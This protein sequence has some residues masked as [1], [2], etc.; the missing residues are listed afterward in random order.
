VALGSDTLILAHTDQL[1]FHPLSALTGGRTPGQRAGGP[2]ASEPD[3][4]MDASRP[5]AS[6]PD[7]S[8]DASRP[9][10]S[11]PDTSMDASQPDSS[12]DASLLDTSVDASGVVTSIAVSSDSRRL[13]VNLGAAEIHLWQLDE[14]G[15]GRRY[16]QRCAISPTFPY[17]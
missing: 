2:P 12:M 11:Q 16:L 17:P 7:T 6:H 1:C 13:L 9:S 8:M 5:S 4:S 3:T 14:T 10:A 15:G